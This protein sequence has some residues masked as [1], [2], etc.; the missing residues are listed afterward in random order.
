MRSEV[1]GICKQLKESMDADLKDTLQRFCDVRTWQL[2]EAVHVCGHVFVCVCV[3]DCDMHDGGGEIV[4]MLGLLCS[5]VFV[6]PH[7]VDR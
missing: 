7:V 4:C 1:L 3:C 2:G 5:F 6:H